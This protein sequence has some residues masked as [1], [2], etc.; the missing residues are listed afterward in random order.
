MHDTVHHVRQ[1]SWAL[2]YNN[3]EVVWH[4]HERQQHMAGRVCRVHDLAHH[5]W[6][7]RFGKPGHAALRASG[8][9]N[10]AA[11]RMGSIWFGHA[12]SMRVEPG[13][14]NAQMR[15]KLIV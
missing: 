11:R 4:D 10:D 13:R 1:R 8:N 7:E 14:R 6:S 9:V 15:Q 12:L 3:V 5:A 2:L